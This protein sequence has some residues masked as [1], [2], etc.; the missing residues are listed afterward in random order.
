MAVD[1]YS[2]ARMMHLICAIWHPEVLFKNEQT[3]AM[4]HDEIIASQLSLRYEKV[5][6]PSARSRG[7]EQEADIF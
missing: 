5:A 2:P 3:L 4:V 6:G 1:T 7:H